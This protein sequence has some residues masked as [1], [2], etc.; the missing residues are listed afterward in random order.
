MNLI[1]IGCGKEKADSRK[2]LP[3]RELYTGGLFRQRLAYAESVAH[4]T[5]IN[6]LSAKCG[7]VGLRQHV[8]PYDLTLD[9]ASP[10]AL[11]EWAA[12]VVHSIFEDALNFLNFRRS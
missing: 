7:L 11:A 4:E 5:E 6:I 3:A 10:I 1:L 8:K 2:S 9:D 12:E